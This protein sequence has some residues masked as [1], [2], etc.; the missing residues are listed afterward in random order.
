MEKFMKKLLAI[1]TVALASIT[2]ALAAVPAAVGTALTALET[3]GLAMADLVW[4]IVISLFSAV[5]LFKLF[6]RFANKM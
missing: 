5:M 4:P 6:K 2:N 1:F 3:D